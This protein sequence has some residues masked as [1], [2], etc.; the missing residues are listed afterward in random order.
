MENH[1]ELMK[2]LNNYKKVLDK[3]EIDTINKF[4]GTLREE[5]L[6]QKSSFL[7]L[8]KTKESLLRIYII[9]KNI[10]LIWKKYSVLFFS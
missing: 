6:N 10:F 5:I 4:A 7:D 3:E 1:V 9:R 8:T 2:T